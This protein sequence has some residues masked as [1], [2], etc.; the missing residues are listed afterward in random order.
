MLV[1]VN[2]R[3]PFPCQCPHC[4]AHITTELSFVA[5]GFTFL[6]CVG[7]LLLGCWPCAIVPFCVPD[8]KSAVHVCPR[9]RGVVA[10]A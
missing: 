3:Q 8:C 9:C 6:G 7:L 10:V 1:Q 5:N 4:A 2:P